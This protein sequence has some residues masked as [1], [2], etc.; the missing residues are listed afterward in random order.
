MCTQ[1]NAT[2]QH[3]GHQVVGFF[4][5]WE[6]QSLYNSNISGRHDALSAMYLKTTFNTMF[7]QQNVVLPFVDDFDV[8]RL[9][10]QVH[11]IHT[12]GQPAVYEDSASDLSGTRPILCNAFIPW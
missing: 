9:K 11:E 2:T 7:N 12:T 1:K 5:W 4:H 6:V 8:A 10:H 3:Q